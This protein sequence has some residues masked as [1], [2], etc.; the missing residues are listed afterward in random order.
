MLPLYPSVSEQL[1][2]IEK[3]CT[4][5]GLTI[6]QTEYTTDKGITFVYCY[7]TG[8]YGNPVYIT[9]TMLVRRDYAELLNSSSRSYA[10][11]LY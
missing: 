7:V 5:N 2:A 10:S 9:Y 1:A 4:R 11:I 6:A 8:N 3:H